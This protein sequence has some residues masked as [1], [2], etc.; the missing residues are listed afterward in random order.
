[1]SITE[2]FLSRS[3]SMPSRNIKKSSLAEPSLPLGLAVELEIARKTGAFDPLPNLS[4]DENSLF[5]AEISKHEV[6]EAIRSR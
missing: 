6:Q 3:D 4:S 2:Y 5:N 1:M